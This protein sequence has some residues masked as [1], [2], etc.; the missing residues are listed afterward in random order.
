MEE[1][2]DITWWTQATDRLFAVTEDARLVA[3]LDFETSGRYF[4][5]DG[6]KHGADVLVARVRDTGC[7]KEALV[8]PILF[9]YRQY[10]ELRLKEVIRYD[11]TSTTVAPTHDLSRLWSSARHIIQNRYGE[12]GT[13]VLDAVES[14][15]V[16][17]GA[18][19]PNSTAFRYADRPTL[20]SSQIGYVDLIHLQ[21]V[22]ER[23][24]EFLDEV[25]MTTLNGE[26]FLP[27]IEFAFEG[28]DDD[29]YC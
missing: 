16:E 12:V 23:L 10:I 26:H 6:Y 21:Q 20:Y 9:L 27:S 1:A 7:S 19:D 22:M 15:I 5:A 8:F 18:V 14:V 24:S 13:G 4:I 11:G 25:S 17:F 29:R 28:V 2:L 3:S